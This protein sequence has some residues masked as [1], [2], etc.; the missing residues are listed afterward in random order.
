MQSSCFI[1]SWSWVTDG[2][3]IQQTVSR[4]F[5]QSPSIQTCWELTHTWMFSLAVSL[6]LYFRTAPLKISAKEHGVLLLKLQM[7]WKLPEGC[8]THQAKFNTAITNATIVIQSNWVLLSFQ[9]CVVINSF[10]KGFPK[11]CLG[12]IRV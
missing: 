4:L 6:F 12:L 8:W 1:F 11:V 10:S 5:L 9:K 3:E 7:G 2:R